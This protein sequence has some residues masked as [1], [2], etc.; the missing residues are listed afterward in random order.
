LYSCITSESQFFKGVFD[1]KQIVIITWCPLGLIG[2]GQLAPLLPLDPALSSGAFTNLRE[3]PLETEGPNL[4][5]FQMN[6]HLAKLQV[7]CKKVKGRSQK[8][9]H[10]KSKQ[11][12]FN[13]P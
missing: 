12:H 5:K 10:S 4:E 2:P 7:S 11:L 9:T 3:T 13:M 1:L 6:S 8:V